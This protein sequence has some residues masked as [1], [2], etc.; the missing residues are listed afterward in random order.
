MRTTSTRKA[1]T[2]QKISFQTGRI[3]FG[4]SFVSVPASVACSPSST[5]VAVVLAS[6][7]G[8]ANTCVPTAAMVAVMWAPASR[9]RWR[10]GELQEDEDHEADE[11]QGLREG[12]AE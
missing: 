10:S 8:R 2:F 6:D 1:P 3:G 12:D 9:W 11:G 4:A 5:V 7:A